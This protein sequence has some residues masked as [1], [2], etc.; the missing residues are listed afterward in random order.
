MGFIHMRFDDFSHAECDRS[1]D[2]CTGDGPDLC[3][4]CAD[5]YELRNGLCTGT[6]YIVGS[7]LLL[8]DL[9]PCCVE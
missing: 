7:T 5:G 6:E 4:K 1:C 8:I 2:G 3:D 9:F